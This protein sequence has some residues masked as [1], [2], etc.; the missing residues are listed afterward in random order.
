MFTQCK[1][2]SKGKTKQYQI[3]LT[4]PDWDVDPDG[5]SGYGKITTLVPVCKK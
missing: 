4:I 2:K 3:D 1:V 5:K